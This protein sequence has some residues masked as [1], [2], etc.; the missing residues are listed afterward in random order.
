M[1]YEIA[2]EVLD[3]IQEIHEGKRKEYFSSEEPTSNLISKQ[4]NDV[5]KDKYVM[6]DQVTNSEEDILE[7]VIHLRRILNLS[8]KRIINLK[9]KLQACDNK[10]HV[11]VESKQYFEGLEAKIVSLRGV[12]ENSNKQKEELLEV[13]EEED[14]RLK[15]EIIKLKEKLEEG[16]KV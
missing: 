12:L 1:H 2:N 5:T 10:D 8:Q 3:N 4:N 7:E 11:T 15:K 6:S 16:R 14:N 9:N 13:F